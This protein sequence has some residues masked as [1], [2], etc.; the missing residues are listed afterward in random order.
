MPSNI[1]APTIKISAEDDASKVFQDS[2][3]K[4]ADSMTDAGKKVKLS[5]DEAKKKLGEYG[6]SLKKGVANAGAYSAGVILA[7]GAMAIKGAKDLGSLAEEIDNMSKQTGIAKDAIQGMKLA[8][9]QTGV[10]LGTFEVATKKLTLNL[11]AMEEGGVKSQKSI[12]ELG[13]NF[14]D[15]IKL[16]VEE[17][18][19]KV[20]NAIA[21]VEDEGKKTTYAVELL[22]KSGTDLNA[23]FGEG[24]DTIKTWTDRTR[25]AGQLLS[26]ETLDAALAAD[27]AF[28]N[29]DATMKGLV[30]T[31]GVQVM[32]TVTKL[33]EAIAPVL[34]QAAE[35]VQKNPELVEAVVK[36][37]GV[38]LGAVAGLGALVKT[39]DALW[40]TIK[41]AQA[42]SAVLTTL[43]GISLL[44][45]AGIAA[46]V[47][48]LGWVALN[49]GTVSNGLEEIA[50]W[51][52]IID[53]TSA[54]AKES[55]KRFQDTASGF[56]MSQET[57]DNYAYAMGGKELRGGPSVGNA[58]AGTLNAGAVQT[59]WGTLAPKTGLFGKTGFLGLGFAGG[60]DPPVGQASMVGEQGPELFIPKTR[61]TIVPNHALGGS[62][63]VINITG[64]TLWSARAA[65]EL[66]DMAFKK[67][68]YTKKIA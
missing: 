51:L 8:A 13:L 12:K 56:K 65:E 34:R 64:N 66:L 18:L 42:M 14:K 47:I 7:F 48:A 30:T 21:K 29:Y 27:T 6:E 28:D 15:L 2:A 49:W 62:S 40:A 59:T 22:G 25:E 3:K 53:E 33:V 1:E 17:Q 46:L 45:F 44:Q 63:T 24:N 31:I 4:I 32:P 37:G 58:A 16:P 41:G 55:L 19:F 10:P 5:M 38:I 60:G 9:D 54:E 39:F 11:Q 23:V 67:I 43:T 50:K 36:W 35:W 20:G 57:K 61:G 26:N 68:R 52:G